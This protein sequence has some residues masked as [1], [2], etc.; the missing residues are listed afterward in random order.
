MYSR[1]YLIIRRELELESNFWKSR[2]V[3][4]NLSFAVCEKQMLGMLYF[5]DICSQTKPACLRQP[6]DLL[7]AHKLSKTVYNFDDILTSL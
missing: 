1:P 6:Q 5:F 3:V 4:V 2:V 7:V